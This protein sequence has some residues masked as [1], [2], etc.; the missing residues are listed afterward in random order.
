MG[1]NEK[2]SRERQSRPKRLDF[3]PVS[4]LIY[5]SFDVTIFLN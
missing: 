2:S 4:V 5:C 1:E 3:F